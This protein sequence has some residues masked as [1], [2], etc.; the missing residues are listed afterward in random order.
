MNI[1]ELRKKRTDLD[2][3]KHKLEIIKSDKSLIHILKIPDSTTHSFYFI[4]SCGV[5]AV[6]GDYGN[7]IFCREF[8]PSKNGYVSS[9]YWVEKLEIGSTQKPMEYDS[10]ETEEEIIERINE[11]KNNEYCESKEKAEEY[12]E[13]LENCIYH[14]DDEVE[15][16]NYAYRTYPNWMDYESVIKCNK[17]NILG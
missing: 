8:H 15:Y 10:K 13:Y 3:S 12:I 5:L 1:E 14:A 2:F 9:R 17:M 11:V 16:D 7:W 6:T 4:N